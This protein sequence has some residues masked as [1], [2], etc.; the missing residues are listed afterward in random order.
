[1]SCSEKV[2]ENEQHL[3]RSPQGTSTGWGWWTLGRAV[4][5]GGYEIQSAWIHASQTD[6]DTARKVGKTPQ[7]SINDLY[8]SQIARYLGLLGSS[9]CPGRAITQ[10][11]FGPLNAMTWEPNHLED[12]DVQWL[13]P[14]VMTDLGAVFYAHLRKDRYSNTLD[15]KL[16]DLA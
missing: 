9:E 14:S 10:S 1:M 2:C 11:P 16:A 4:G 3:E 15:R 6:L 5:P 7:G 13:W 12:R 8:L